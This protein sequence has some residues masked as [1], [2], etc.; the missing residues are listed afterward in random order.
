MNYS[1]KN[2]I[3]ALTKAFGLISTQGDSMPLR[4]RILEIIPSIVDIAGELKKKEKLELLKEIAQSITKTITSLQSIAAR[5]KDSP[6]RFEIYEAAR[7]LLEA[8]RREI[9]EAISLEITPKGPEQL[10]FSGTEVEEEKEQ[11]QEV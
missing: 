10:T 1:I 3:L 6:K 5:H 7:Q 8:A 9:W 4:G 2:A 11:T